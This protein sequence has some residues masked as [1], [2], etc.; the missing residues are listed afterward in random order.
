M[1]PNLKVFILSIVLGL[2][3]IIGIWVI[4]DQNLDAAASRSQFTDQRDGLTAGVSWLIENNQN[5]DGGYGL[6][7]SS[8]PSTLDPIIAIASAGYNPA[9]AYGDFTTSPIDYLAA[10]SEA[11]SEYVSGSGGSAGK[12]VLALVAANQNPRDFAGENWILKLT[13]QYTET[14]QYNTN[15]AYNQSLAI[16]GVT[17][18]NE[19]VPSLAVTWL[20]GIQADNGSWGDGFGTDNNPDTTA[21]AIMAMASQGITPGDPALDKALDFLK[22]TQMP[23][24]GWE[25]GSGY[26]ENANSTA[27]VIQALAANGQNFYDDKGDWSKNGR[28]PLT[29]L[30]SW[31]NVN[32]AFQ[33]DF[34]SGLEDNLFATVQSLPALTGK[35]LPIPGRFEAAQMALS[36]LET[37]QDPVTGGWAQFAGFNVNAAGTSRA[38]QA[39]SAVGEDPKSDLWTPGSVNAVDALE[40][41]TPDYL[42]SGRGGRVGIVMRG[43]VSAGAPFDVSNFAG[44]DLPVLVSGYLSP[45]GEYDDTS[46]GVVAQNEAMLGLISAGFDVDPSAVDFLVNAQT[47]G[48]WASPDGNGISLNTLSRLGIS[49]PDAISFLRSSQQGDGGWGFGIPSDPSSTSEI[50][51][52]LIQ[53]GNNPFSPRWSKISAGKVVNAADAVMAL[54][55]ENGCWPNLFGPGDDPFGTTDAIKLL[56]QQAQWEEPYMAFFPG[57]LK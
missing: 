23:T 35:P 27:L 26:G 11:L 32:G 34:G 29:A 8:P 38:I 36:C 55:E 15:D 3:L 21:L 39:I 52:G 5:S 46:F 43:V 10:N 49:L 50:V 51:Q 44:I 25:Y 57:V 12:A 13:E 7:V 18:V 20:K 42:S 40:T 56:A 19:T 2:V 45:T 30:M 14:G 1:K 41:L 31:Q 17:A 48:D 37:L 6:P 24:G 28:S 16:L 22:S 47:G 54:Q 4:L 9:V 53:S 33:A